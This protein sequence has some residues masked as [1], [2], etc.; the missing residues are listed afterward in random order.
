MKIWAVSNQKGGV[1][2]TTSVVTLGG[3]LSTWGFKT[4][5]L[6]LDP[7]GSM[8]SYFGLNPDTIDVSVYDLFEAASHGK[9]INP[10]PAVVKTNF[11]GLFLLPAASGI[12][13]LDRQCATAEG[14]GLVITRALSMIADNYDYVLIDSPPMLAC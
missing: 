6:D 5:L 8:S 14:M 12:A 7:H 9:S 3:L 2:K 10:V 1:G 11:Q 13:T 4:L